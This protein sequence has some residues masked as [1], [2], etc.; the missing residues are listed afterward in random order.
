MDKETAKAAIRAEMVRR[1]SFSGGPDVLRRFARAPSD[2]AEAALRELVAEGF[3]NEIPLRVGRLYSFPPE[4]R[5]SHD[6]LADQL[7]KMKEEAAARPARPARAAHAAPRP[8]PV[9]T[10]L[11]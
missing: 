10:G 6:Y 2:V 9:G 3:L 5:P 4:T 1:S 7:A 8:A 11:A